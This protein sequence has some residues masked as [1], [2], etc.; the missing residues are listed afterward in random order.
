MLWAPYT[1]LDCAIR[2]LAILR[3]PLSV[4]RTLKSNN[5]PLT[6]VFL[7]F[8]LFFCLFLVF[9]VVVVVCLFVCL[10][11]LFIVADLLLL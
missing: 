4:D 11:F 5:W 8:C 3:W 2:P 10:M 7:R 6:I 9:V 1:V